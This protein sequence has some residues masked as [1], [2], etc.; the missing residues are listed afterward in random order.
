MPF[1]LCEEDIFEKKAPHP[2]SESI[3]N[4][5]A[6]TTVISVF[7][8]CSETPTFFQYLVALGFIRKD[9]WD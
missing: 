7:L 5:L 1:E 8:L 2:D 9:I 6:S 3:L 4:S